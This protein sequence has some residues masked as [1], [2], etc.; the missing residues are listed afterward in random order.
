MAETRQRSIA[1]APTSLDLTEQ[2]W[3]NCCKF[4]PFVAAHC[5]RPRPNVGP[6]HPLD[7]T[8]AMG[9]MLRG[10]AALV[11]PRRGDDPDAL[12]ERAA[13]QNEPA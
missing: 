5:K 12:E 1:S 9:P 11:A 10:R 4:W 7:A 3:Y 13:I 8:A 6:D 2:Q